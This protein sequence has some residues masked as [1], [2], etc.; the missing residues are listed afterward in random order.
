MIGKVVA[1]PFFV[2]PANVFIIFDKGKGRQGI[3][4]YIGRRYNNYIGRRYNE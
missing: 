3:D 2:H 4:N 1:E